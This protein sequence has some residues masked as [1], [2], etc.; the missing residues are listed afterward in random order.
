MPCLSLR[1]RFRNLSFARPN[2]AISEQ[3]CAPHSTARNAINRISIR[4]WRE[5][6]ALGSGTLSNAVRKSCI[7]D[8]LQSAGGGFK[9]PK[10]RRCKPPQ[11]M[12]YAIPLPLIL[13]LGH[14]SCGAIEAT[15]KSIKDGTTLPGHMAKLVTALA[16]AV[17]AVQGAHGDLL[18]NAIRQ[19][20]TLNVE[21]LK[22]S[23][24]ILK[25]FAD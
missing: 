14:E 18:A 4:S 6:L 13:V 15:I 12:S 21:M 7:G 23:A 10:F 1:K 17:N 2:A 25:S 5:F 16:P 11:L 22:T 8:P 3:C 24:P 19:N 9:I 20:V